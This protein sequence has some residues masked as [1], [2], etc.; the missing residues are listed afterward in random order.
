MSLWEKDEATSSMGCKLWEVMTKGPIVPKKKKEEWKIVSH[1]V[2][3]RP[4][5]EANDEL[6]QEQLS[7]DQRGDQNPPKILLE[8]QVVT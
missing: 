4:K 7:R 8:R 6:D 5:R 2:V 3:S 1:E